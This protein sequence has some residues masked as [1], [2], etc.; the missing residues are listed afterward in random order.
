MPK[1]RRE[2]ILPE[3]HHGLEQTLLIP[4]DLSCRI[5]FE[6]LHSLLDL[7]L[8]MSL[9]GA[10]QPLFNEWNERRREQ[11]HSLENILPRALGHVLFPLKY[12]AGSDRKSVV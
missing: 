2:G 6:T 10:F 9:D 3:C 1:H 4:A 11:L 7:D 5:G 12:P 8:P